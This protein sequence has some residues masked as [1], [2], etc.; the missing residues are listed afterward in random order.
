MF[1]Q[2]Y[3]EFS[4]LSAEIVE[5]IGRVY[6]TPDGNKYPSVTTVLGAG[7]DQS[8]LQEWKDRVGEKEARSRIIFTWRFTI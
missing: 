6:T 5:G 1:K 7:S 4:E 2:E 8:W 3:M